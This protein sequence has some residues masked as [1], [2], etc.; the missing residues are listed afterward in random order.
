V[1]E[2]TIFHIICSRIIETTRLPSPQLPTPA[3]SS[4]VTSTYV[5]SLQKSSRRRK[6]LGREET[7][8]LF[9]Q[10][11]AVFLGSAIQRD[12]ENSNFT[13]PLADP[14]L[15]PIIAK[16]SQDSPQSSDPATRQNMVPTSIHDPSTGR[17]VTFLS[18]TAIPQYSSNSFEVVVAMCYHLLLCVYYLS[19][20]FQHVGATSSGVF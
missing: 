3:S 10:T 7:P 6:K 8:K 20:T 1:Y 18:I 16:S 14:K 15:N 5:P 11:P 4:Q 13:Q 19:I 12:I 2:G 9:S 17:H